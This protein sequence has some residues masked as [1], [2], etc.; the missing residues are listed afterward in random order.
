MFYILASVQKLQISKCVYI[1]TRFW[2]SS[3]LQEETIEYLD[4]VM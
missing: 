1:R 3:V 4:Y 2:L